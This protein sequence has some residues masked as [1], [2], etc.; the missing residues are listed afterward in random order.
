MAWIKRNLYFLISTLVAVGLIVA[1]VMYLLGEMSDKAGVTEEIEKQYNTLKNL[2]QANPNPGEAGGKG[3]NVQASKDQQVALR[4]YVEKLRPYFKRIPPVPDLPANR[5]TGAEFAKQL[6]TTLIQLQHDA[7]S[8]GVA[9]P[10]DYAFTFQHQ[11]EIMTIDSA[12][13]PKLAMHLGEIKTLCGI[14]FDA[15]IKALE[16]LEREVVVPNEN[17]KNPGD[18]LPIE[19]KTTVNPVAQAELTPYHVTIECFTAELAEVLGNLA[20]VPLGFVVKA[21]DVEPASSASTAATTMSSSMPGMIPGPRS[22]RGGVIAGG[23]R[24]GASGRGPATL[25]DEHALRVSLTILVVKP[26]QPGK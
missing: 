15:R 10:K 22:S 11:K 26:R 18:Y 17:V 6:G 8:R 16:R 5:Q 21:I 3:D 9:I 13:V 7:E 4:E 12:S 24:G 1:G 2:T 20:T 14:L 25:L 23:G 19:L